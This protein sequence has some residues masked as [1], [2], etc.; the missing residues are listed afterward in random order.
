MS[1]NFTIVENLSKNL[2]ST[3]KPFQTFQ[4]LKA[5]NLSN[6]K[7]SQHPIKLMLI[8]NNRNPRKMYEITTS[9]WCLYC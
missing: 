3:V 5:E 6:A 8:F 9:F 2:F 1:K 7:L 4:T